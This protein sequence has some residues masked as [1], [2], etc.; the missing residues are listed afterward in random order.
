MLGYPP[1]TLEEASFWQPENPALSRPHVLCFLARDPQGRSAVS[2]Y[3]SRHPQNARDTATGTCMLSAGTP[4]L[5]SGRAELGL[6]RRSLGV[7][8]R[9]SRDPENGRLLKS[10]P[11]RAPPLQGQR[12]QNCAN[13]REA[14]ERGPLQRFTLGPSLASLRSCPT[15]DGVE[16]SPQAKARAP[17]LPSRSHGTLGNSAPPLSR[18]FWLCDSRVTLLLSA[19]KQNNSSSMHYLDLIDACLNSIASQKHP[20]TCRPQSC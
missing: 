12:S 14:P 6:R 2:D 16:P 8:F 17:A 1:R 9:E 18:L 11:L 3:I 20:L 10:G 5:L 13:G 4:S 19:I 7:T 15:R